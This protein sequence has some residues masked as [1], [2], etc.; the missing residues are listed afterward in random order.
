[1]ARPVFFA[2]AV[3]ILALDQLS[4]FL[5]VRVLPE[6]ASFNILPG[7]FYLTHT[8]NTGAAFGVFPRATPVLALT[9]LVAVVGI[10]VYALRASWPVTYLVGTALALPLGGATGNFL[11]RARLGYVVDFLDVRIGA[12]SWPVFNVA[13]SAICIGV[14]LLAYTA[15]RS[16]PVAEPSG[17]EVS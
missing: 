1:M 9:A 4:K 13:D 5:I 17:G 3:L 7:V 12:F 16:R 15:L 6:G 10:I 8:T 14:G 2:L 11:D